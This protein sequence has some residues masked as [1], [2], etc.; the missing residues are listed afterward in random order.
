M[1]RCAYI[2]MQ[3]VVIPV[4][5]FSESSLIAD[6]NHLNDNM[7][8]STFLNFTKTFSGVESLSVMI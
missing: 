1:H 5:F 3:I 6:R 7:Q 4:L 2:V 8:A